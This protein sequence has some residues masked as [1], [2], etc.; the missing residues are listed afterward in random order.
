M[1]AL[2]AWKFLVTLLITFAAVDFGN[3]ELN[4]IEKPSDHLSITP[5]PLS[6]F[7]EHKSK[8]Q[9]LGQQPISIFAND[10]SYEQLLCIGFNPSLNLLSAT[11]EIKLPDGFNGGLCTNGSFEYVRFWVSYDGSTWTGIGYVTANTHDIADSFDCQKNSTKPLFYTLSTQFTPP[12][13]FC[14]TPLL[15]KIRATLSWNELPPDV[16]SW[17]PVWGNTIETHIQA[18]PGVITPDIYTT[19]IDT[20]PTRH[21][22]GKSHG[23]S[24][25][26][27]MWLLSA[28]RGVRDGLSFLGARMGLIGK[29]DLEVKVEKGRSDLAQVDEQSA[30]TSNWEEI[31]CLGLDWAANSLIAT[32]HVKQP[33]G[34]GSPPCVGL[35][36]EYV[37][38][39]ADFNNSCQWT[40]LGTSRFWIHDYTTSFPSGGL[41]Y[42]AVMPID[43]RS[44]SAPCNQT[45]IGRV[46]AAL[47]FNQI[48]PTPPAVAA[49]GNILEAHVHLQ[50]YIKPTNPIQ[51]DIRYIGN[52]DVQ[53][54][55][56]ASG[57]TLTGLDVPVAFSGFADAWLVGTGLARDCAFGGKIY[58]RGDPIVGYSYRVMVRPYISATDTSP[59]V[60]V[61]APIT[62][63]DPLVPSGTAT[64]YPKPDGWFQYLSNQQNYENTIAVWTPAHDGLWQVR[65]ELGDPNY[66]SLNVYSNWYLVMVNNLQPTANTVHVSLS[67]TGGS[68]CGNWTVGDNVTGIFDVNS[69][70]RY[71]GVYSFGL[72][73]GGFDPNPIVLPNAVALGYPL[74]P[75]PPG[76][77]WSDVGVENN[78]C[79]S[80]RLC[81]YTYRVRSNDFG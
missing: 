65:V 13:W 2:K 23:S 17:S 78:W 1:E 20:L 43:V 70:S 11:I 32:V 4:T 73:P 26:T 54:I 18:Q 79:N 53:N 74:K 64:I 68:L 8:P 63:D 15:P 31:T 48:P 14:M 80:L 71:F 7:R 27:S 29:R 45:K 62:Y 46:R 21:E 38:F 66:N 50:P 41:S 56:P 59:G 35:R 3:S 28:G 6:H 22:C 81:C 72:L 58:I 42:T 25:E 30:Q 69:L 37:S 34:Y 60:A 19:G 10:T 52:V 36:S 5:N 44:F 49:R 47:A 61:N 55:D 57:T 33:N 67:N 76:R 51:P 16:P 40:F 39:W 12:G 75:V 9:P 77:P 24:G